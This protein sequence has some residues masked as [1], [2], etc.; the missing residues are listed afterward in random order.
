[1]S[2]IIGKVIKDLGCGVDMCVVGVVEDVKVGNVKDVNL[3]IM[4]LC[5]FNFLLFVLELILMID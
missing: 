4:F 2:D 1:M 3:N 5:G